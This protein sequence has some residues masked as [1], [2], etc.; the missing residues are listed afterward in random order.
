MGFCG[1]KADA[2]SVKDGVLQ[3]ECFVDVLNI[4]PHATLALIGIFIVTGLEPLCH[5]KIESKDMGP[6]SGPQFPL[7]FNPHP[8]LH[9]HH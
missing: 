4:I 9:H 8:S 7:D 6:F 5:G 1:T 3:N 2:M